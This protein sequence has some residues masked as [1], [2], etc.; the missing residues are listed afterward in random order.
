VTGTETAA[1]MRR[2][3]GSDYRIETF[4]TPLNT[5]A[6]ETRHMDPSYIADGNNITD[7]SYERP[8]I[9]LPWV[10]RASPSIWTKSITARSASA[11]TPSS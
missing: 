2:V 11:R 1:A 9:C 6:R 8:S 3:A 5:V 7:A 4:V 10:R